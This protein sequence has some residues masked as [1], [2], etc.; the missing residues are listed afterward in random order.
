MDDIRFTAFTELSLMGLLWKGKGMLDCIG[1][2]DMLI[3][4]RYRTLNIIDSGYVF[5]I[6]GI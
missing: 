5:Y 2:S 4:V 3:E 6:D 1:G